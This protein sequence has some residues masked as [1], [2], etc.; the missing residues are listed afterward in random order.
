M[1][2]RSAIIVTNM[3]ERVPVVDPTSIS[4]DLAVKTRDLEIKA[5]EFFFL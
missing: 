5:I 4:G 3:N 2:P 1:T